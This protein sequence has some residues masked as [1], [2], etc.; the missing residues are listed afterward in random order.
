VKDGYLVT[1]SEESNEALS[2]ISEI[3]DVFSYL[4][5]EQKQKLEG[6]E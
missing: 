3:L 5:K 1:K 2:S 4:L 6:K